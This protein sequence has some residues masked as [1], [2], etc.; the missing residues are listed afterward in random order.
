MLSIVIPTKNEE[1]YLPKLL[2]SIKKQTLQP[3]EVIV[4]DA[5][6]TDKTRQIAESFGARVVDGGL[7]GPGRN[8]GAEA[9]KGDYLLFLDAD[10]ELKD[11]HFLESAMAEM[12]ERKLD[13]AIC[14]SE[15]QSEKI[16]D[17]LMHE[18]YNGYN[19]L[20]AKI[21]PHA[22]GYCIFARRAAHEQLHGFDE[23]VVFCEDTDY[24]NRGQK[25]G[26]FGILRSVTI[27]V[28][29]RRLE[30]D[31]RFETALRMALA[32]VYMVTM[33]PI[34]SNIFNYSFGHKK[35]K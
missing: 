29:V 22:P 34:R 4:A 5:W 7:P 18:I 15:P 2:A 24:V 11:V 27:P 31:G 1:E 30:R 16:S 3:L 12:I 28:S 23:S 6:S 25:I 33:G 14:D 20:L 9:A 13:F 32:E 26:S 21:R 35:V 8:R 17:K 10:V 19:R